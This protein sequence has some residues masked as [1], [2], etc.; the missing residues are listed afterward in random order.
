MKKNIAHEYLSKEKL[1][2]YINR[3]NKNKKVV[4]HKTTNLLCNEERNSRRYNSHE[5][6]TASKCRKHTFQD[7]VSLFTEG[8]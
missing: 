3:K 6:E 7:P 8:E 5:A 2:K 4:L 1:C